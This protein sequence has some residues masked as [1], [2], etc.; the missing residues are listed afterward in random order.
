M[1][2]TRLNRA[3]LVATVFLAAVFAASAQTL[4]VGNGEK[5]GF[6]QKFKHIFASPATIHYLLSTF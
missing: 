4:I 5:P 2:F 3:V 1:P 6:D